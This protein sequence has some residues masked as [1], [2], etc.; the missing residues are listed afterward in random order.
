VTATGSG[1]G[2]LETTSRSSPSPLGAL[3]EVA[4]AHSSVGVYVHVPFCTRRC[5]YCSFNTAPIDDREVVSRYLA[6][7]KAEIALLGAAGWA[8][9]LTVETIFLGGGTPS[10]LEV[11]EMEGV[12]GALGRAFAVEATA[13]V[14]VECNPESVTPAKLAGYRRAGVNRIS[15][16]VQSLDD[17]MLPAIGRLH[18]AAEARAAFEAARAAG[19]DNVSVDLIYG[20]PGLTP[21]SW[22]STVDGVLGWRPEHVSAYGL[23]LDP[24]S[25]WGSSGVH[26]L[27]GEDAVIGHYWTMAE[28]ARA[29]D[30]EHYEISN[31]ARAGARSRHNQIYWRR[32]EYLACG[33]GAAGFLGDVR[34]VNVKPVR[35][36]VQLLEDGRLP[37]DTCERLTPPQALAETLILGLR[38]GDGVEIERLNAR[39]AGDPA[40]ERRLAGWRDQ[41]LLIDEGGRARLTESG[42]LLSDALFVD[43]L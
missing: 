33:P 13:E 18:T 14:T 1:G 40:L 16:G 38:T 15:L 4:P 11:G 12:L 10:L 19:F 21:E 7:L 42:F 24:G 9:G 30:Y 43:L 22:R 23:T 17:A 25:V 5:E 26:G 34:H 32:R 27:P 35:R 41:G 36:Y 28:R 37:I 20:L 29:Q 2:D 3:A 31:Y 39:S 8:R 6:A